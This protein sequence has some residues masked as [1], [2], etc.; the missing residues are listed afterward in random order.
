MCEIH[1]VLKP[2]GR[3]II[4]HFY[5]R[6]S[7]LHWLSRIV[8]ENI[9]FEDEDPPVTDFLTEANILQMFQGFIIVEALQEHYRALPIGRTG[10]KAEL[11]GWGFRPLFNLLPKVVAKRLAHKF[12]VTA[13]KR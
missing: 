6:P 8:G 1:R 5:R 12:S 13:I 10:F 7:W 11:Y 9:E 4:S 2:Q 3:A